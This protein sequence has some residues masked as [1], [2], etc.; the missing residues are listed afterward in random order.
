M[1]PKADCSGKRQLKNLVKMHIRV[2]NACLSFHISC[3]I[4]LGRW[5][6]IIKNSDRPG[7][8]FAQGFSSFHSLCFYSAECHCW[9]YDRESKKRINRGFKSLHQKVI[10]SLFIKIRAN[11]E[12]R[13]VHTLVAIYYFRALE[14]G[15]QNL[16]MGMM[17]SDALDL[18]LSKD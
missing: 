7:M 9:L 13:E 15:C 3:S 5:G 16:L 12:A 1:S 4:N 18:C 10:F 8:W 6:D 11:E 17:V 14:W 2:L